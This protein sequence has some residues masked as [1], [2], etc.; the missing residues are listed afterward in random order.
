MV[1]GGGEGE[2]LHASTLDT[3]AKATKLPNDF[4]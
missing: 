3:L 4:F 1:G 2:I